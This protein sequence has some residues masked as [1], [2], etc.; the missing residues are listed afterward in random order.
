[1]VVAAPTCPVR[2]AG[3]GVA[4]DA[5]TGTEPRTEDTVLEL[6]SDQPAWRLIVRV[7]IARARATLGAPRGRFAQ[8]A[9]GQDPPRP[10]PLLA[11]S[12]AG[13]LR[14]EVIVSPAERCAFTLLLQPPR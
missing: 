1:V 14:C 7:D 13:P 4:A 3:P 2:V 12:L 11:L 8:V 9:C 6:A 10:T 5:P